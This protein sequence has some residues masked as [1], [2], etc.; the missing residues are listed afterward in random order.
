MIHPHN[1]RLHKFL[2]IR[3]IG[4]I[5]N[6]SLSLARIFDLPR[7]RIDR[8]PRQIRRPP[9]QRGKPVE[10][11]RL[12]TFILFEL[13]PHAWEHCTA[14]ARVHGEVGGRHFPDVEVEVHVE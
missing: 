5:D 11:P 2:R 12:V 7:R 10:Q 14:R 3:N 13:E 4:G 9:R 8:D 1:T 6:I